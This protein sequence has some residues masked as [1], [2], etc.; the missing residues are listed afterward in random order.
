MRCLNK[1]RNCWM[2]NAFIF[3]KIMTIFLNFYIVVYLITLIKLNYILINLV[4]NQNSQNSISQLFT[5]IL[6]FNKFKSLIFI[7]ILSL[8]GLPP[9]MI[10]FIKFNFLINLL[11][12]NNIFIILLIFF[13]FFFNMLFYIQIFFH[14][15]LDVSFNFLKNKKNFKFNYNKIYFIMWFITFN[16][17]N[18]F[19]FTNFLFI[20]K[21][22][23]NGNI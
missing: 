6:K 5:Y 20:F 3:L 15:N 23:I 16:F 13:I 1:N 12:K 19:F 10:F 9:F 17:L 18:V 14:K 21:L 4:F 22:I 2:Y 11:Y 8:A 7:L